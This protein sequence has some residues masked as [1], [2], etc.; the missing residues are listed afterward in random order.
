M[1]T[2]LRRPRGANPDVRFMNA[3][4]LRPWY[5]GLAWAMPPAVALDRARD[6]DHAKEA[7]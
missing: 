7:P 3:A 5:A 1:S 4:A 6:V 2:V